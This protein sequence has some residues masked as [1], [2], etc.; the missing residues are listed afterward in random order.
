MN[1]EKILAMESWFIV[2]ILE[3]ATCSGTRTTWYCCSGKR[4]PGAVGYTC[5]KRMCLSHEVSTANNLLMSPFFRRT[6]YPQ[7][8]LVEI[9]L[10]NIDFLVF[11]NASAGAL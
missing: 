8:I 10:T 2:M 1:E 4:L 11:I 9:K 7:C 6:N 5:W 3:P